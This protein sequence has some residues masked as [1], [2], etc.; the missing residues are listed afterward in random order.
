MWKHGGDPVVERRSAQILVVVASTYVR[1]V[2][3]EEEKGFIRTVIGYELV[4]PNARLEGFLG[5]T[6]L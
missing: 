2:W 4:G 3:A 5:M 1:D 6:V